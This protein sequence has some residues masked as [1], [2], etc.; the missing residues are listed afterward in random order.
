[1]HQMAL[2]SLSHL[3]LPRGFKK[4]LLLLLAFEKLLKDMRQ[5]RVV[6]FS[7]RVCVLNATHIHFC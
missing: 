4:H 1:M 7:E 6:T 3:G 5:K 2:S